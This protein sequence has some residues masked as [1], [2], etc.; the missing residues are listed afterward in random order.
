MTNHGRGSHSCQALMQTPWNW[1]AKTIH[2]TPPVSVRST[3]R[4]PHASILSPC[5]TTGPDSQ[6]RRAGLEASMLR[7]PRNRAQ[8]RAV[9]G[10]RA[11]LEAPMLL[12]AA[13]KGSATALP[14]WRWKPCSRGGLCADLIPMS[15]MHL[16]AAHVSG[17]WWFSFVFE[18]LWDK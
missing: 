15:A 6:S 5:L 11:G 9:F 17:W 13:E 3:V 1:V 16:V 2:E 10:K 18:N 8:D 7:L 4:G 12:A 14:L